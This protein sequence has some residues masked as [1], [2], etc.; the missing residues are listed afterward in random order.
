[1]ERSETAIISPLRLTEESGND[2]RPKDP[3]WI[4]EDERTKLQI[5]DKDALS[6]KVK[7][8]QAAL[9]QRTAEQFQRMRSLEETERQNQVMEEGLKRFQS[10]LVSVQAR[11]QDLQSEVK[12]LRG[13]MEEISGKLLAGSVDR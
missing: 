6:L 3:P 13:Q 9:K 8:L 10:T 12:S 7:R 2:R 1:M 11:L 5:Q 4:E